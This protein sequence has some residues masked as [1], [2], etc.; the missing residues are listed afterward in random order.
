METADKATSAS[1]ERMLAR[2]AH[3]LLELRTE[4]GWTLEELER[5]TGV[6]HSTLWRFERGVTIPTTIFL[7]KVCNAYEYTVSD[8][9]AEVENEETPASSG[10]VPSSTR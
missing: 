7:A 3:R 8:L 4:R 1:I 6:S 9:F 5:R 2:L 10:P